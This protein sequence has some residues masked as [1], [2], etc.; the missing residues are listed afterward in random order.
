MVMR[1]GEMR[2]RDVIGIRDGTRIGALGDIE[3]DAEKAQLTAVVV[4]GR[5]RLFG[6]LGHED[7]CVIPWQSVRT[8]GE[9]AVLVDFDPPKRPPRRSFWKGLFEERY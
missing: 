3:F 7:D 2:S 5:P 6:L 1:I 4:Y 8:V 9:D